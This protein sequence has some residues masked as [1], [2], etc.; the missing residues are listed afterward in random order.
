MESNCEYCIYY[1]VMMKN[2]TSIIAKLFLILMKTKR[3]LF[4]SSKHCKYFRPG[5]DYTIVRKQI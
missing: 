3:V 5:D 2:L 4:Y 1:V